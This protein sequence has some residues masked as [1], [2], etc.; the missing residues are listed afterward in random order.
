MGQVVLLVVAAAWAAVLLPAAAAFPAGE[1]SELL[2]AR[3]PQPAVQ[4][5]ARRADPW[6]RRPVDGP[7]AG[8]V[9]AQPP[10][11][12]RSSGHPQRGADQRR[13]QLADGADVADD[14]PDPPRRPDAGGHACGPASTVPRAIRRSPPALA[15]SRAAEAKRR[16]ANV[17]FLLVLTTVC[18]GFLAATTDSK[19]MVYLFAVSMVALGGYVY[20]LVTIN[21]Q[22]FGER[23]ESRRATAA[24]RQR[25]A[26]RRR[27]VDADYE[28]T[29]LTTTTGKPRPRPPDSA[30]RRRTR[31][32]RT[33]SRPAADSRDGSPTGAAPS[34]SPRRDP[35]DPVRPR[36]LR[37]GHRHPRD[38][39]A[40]AG[41]QR[42]PRHRPG[43]GAADAP[44]RAVARL[45]LARRLTAIAATPAAP[46]VHWRLR[47]GCSSVGRARQSHCRGQGF[48]SP[49]L[50]RVARWRLAPGSGAALRRCSASGGRSGATESQC[51]GVA[52]APSGGQ[53]SASR[54]R[55]GRSVVGV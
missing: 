8:P 26:P 15:S 28:R 4:P 16:R 24:P 52:G 7:F 50:H 14:P 27:A 10:R 5:A 21:Q 19:A 41:P 40:G 17:L 51:A 32:R 18:A 11:R 13:G 43:A 54:A 38:D 39:A 30:G 9:D 46:P 23:A 53:V 36:G 12:R 47:R 49:Q 20:L 6:R 37:V 35:R 29:T 42:P 3:L 48:D 25:A 55:A 22:Q 34:Q 33:A 2:R 31:R 44:A 45:L 1:S